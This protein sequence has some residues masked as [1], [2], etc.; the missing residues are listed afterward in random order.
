MDLDPATLQL[1]MGVL[2]EL[3]R[4]LRKDPRRDVEVVAGLAIDVGKAV[5]LFKETA[6]LSSCELT[7]GLSAALDQANLPMDLLSRVRGVLAFGDVT[8]KAG[9]IAVASDDAPGLVG[10]IAGHFGVPKWAVAT[11]GPSADGEP[12]RMPEGLQSAI[13]VRCRSQAGGRAANQGGDIQGPAACS[14]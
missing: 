4:D 7:R 3:A 11:F 6:G 2:A 14:R 1:V 8:R 5:S 13:R 10:A 12:M 9:L